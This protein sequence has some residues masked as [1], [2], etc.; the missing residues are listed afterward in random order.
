MSSKDTNLSSGGAVLPFW[1]FADGSKTD[2]S[3]LTEPEEQENLPEEDV[4][5]ADS[6]KTLAAHPE[7]NC[8]KAGMLL[9][10]PGHCD[11]AYRCMR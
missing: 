2:D 4:A 10:H 5:T 11:K 1:Q 6:D 7:L 8:R 3:T 9:M